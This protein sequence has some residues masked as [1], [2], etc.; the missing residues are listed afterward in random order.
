MYQKKNV[1]KQLFIVN[2][3]RYWMCQ[4]SVRSFCVGKRK[5][6]GDYVLCIIS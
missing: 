4:N 1:E 3:L 6:S 2:M 5:Y